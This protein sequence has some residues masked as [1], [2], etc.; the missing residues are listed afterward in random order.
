MALSKLPK[1]FSLKELKKGYFPHFF[2][3]PENKNYIGKYPSLEFYGADLLSSKEREK[4]ISWHSQQTGIFDLQK[5]LLDYCRS[6][7]DILKQSCIA[8]RNLFLEI[9]KKNE[10]DTGVDPFVESLTLA[11]ACHLV[12]RRNFMPENTIGLIPPMGYCAEPTSHKAIIWLK[13]IAMI[14]QVHIQHARNGG[15]KIINDMKI[16]GWDDKNSTAYE[17]HG[18]IYH[19]CQ[20]CYKPESF[21][22]LKNEIMRET[23]KKHLNRISKLQSSSEISK[24]IEIWEC[25]YEKMKLT[26]LKFQ[27]FVNQSQVKQPLDPRNALCGGR[28]N[29]FILHHKGSIGYVDFTSLYPYIQKYGE[30]PLGHPQI[31]TENFNSIEN[32]FGIVYCKILPPQNLYIP[33]LPYKKNGKLMFPLC[34]ACCEMHI[35]NCTHSSDERCLEGTWVSLEILEAIKHGYK[36]IHIYEI[37][38]YDNVLKYDNVSKSG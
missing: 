37:W 30:F 1:T 32:Y 35:I 16:D 21:N 11:S 28:T 25:E 36:I 2:N 17:F 20:N 3:T 4:L 8:F 5:E 34:A 33:V 31:I 38:H 22:P 14:N 19:G 24:L 26:D 6:D 18:C 13:N 27:N 10:S 7:V 9:T 12:Y 29:A 23:Y 15:E